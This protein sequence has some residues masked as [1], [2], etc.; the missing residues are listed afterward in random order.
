MT[1]GPITNG[2]GPFNKFAWIKALLSDAALTDKDFRLAVLIGVTYTRADGI[3]WGIELDALA[4]ALPGGLSRRRLIDALGRL[5]ARGYLVQSGRSG[6]GRGV[7]ARR[8]FDLCKPLTPASG[9]NAETPDASGTG[10]AETPDASVQ[11]PGRQRP[12]PLTPASEKMR[13]ELHKQPP[14]GIATG[15]T[16]GSGASNVV[17]GAP[18]YRELTPDPEPPR[19]CPR[20]PNDDTPC[21][22]CRA[23]KE[24]HEAW[25][26][27]QFVRRRALAE[28][29]ATDIANCRECD[30][31]G[32]FLDPDGTPCEPSFKC[33]H[34]HL[35]HAHWVA[36]GVLEPVD[37]REVTA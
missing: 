24:N 21:G 33:L 32:W 22:A 14:T 6:G 10:F 16:T 15:I 29:Q 2:Q 23:A 19:T 25:R 34:T 31:Q 9:V 35:W 17:T 12:K 13:S 5:V 11:N 36:R 1:S 28:V 27:R 7:T 18:G 8:S 3:G 4:A 20:H 37:D 26:G 30:S